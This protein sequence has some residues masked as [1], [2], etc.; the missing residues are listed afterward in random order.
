MK[1]LK[2]DRLYTVKELRPKSEYQITDKDGIVFHYYL[3]SN[4]DYELS[5]NLTVNG[6]QIEQ[7]VPITPEIIKGFDEME[8]MCIE[9]EARIITSIKE[10]Y[11]SLGEQ[12]LNRR[13]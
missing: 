6:L 5:A 13:C 9:N 4:L 11:N 12:E 1:F 10:I 8:Q 2:R 7:Y 3:C